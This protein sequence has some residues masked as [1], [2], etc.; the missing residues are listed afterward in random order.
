V[1][2][3]LVIDDDAAIRQ[4]LSRL[5]ISEGF[6]VDTAVDGE[7]GL[8]CVYARRPDLI[9][10][11]LMM[12][13]MDGWQLYGWLQV[14][15]YED[16]PVIVM[17]AGERLEI[18]QQDLPNAEILGK[19]FDIDELIARIRRRLSDEPATTSQLDSRPA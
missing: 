12:P 8:Q 19:P 2:H 3:L 16:I 9:L 15:G 17:T 4:I 11:D 7:K 10:L 18:A 5:L 6:T 1:P 13:V 14:S